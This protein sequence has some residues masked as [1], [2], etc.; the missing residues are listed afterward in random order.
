VAPKGGL[1]WGLITEGTYATGGYLPATQ[2]QLDAWISSASA[3]NTW[4]LDSA[5][6]QPPMETYFSTGRDTYVLIDLS[7]MRIA[8]ID[9]DVTVAL[10]DFNAML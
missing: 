6:S 10:S 8:K 2:P 7:T 1:I 3:P 5:G 9:Y 4:T